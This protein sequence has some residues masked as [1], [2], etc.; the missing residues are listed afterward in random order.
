MKL[1]ILTPG[2]FRPTRFVPGIG[3]PNSF[4]CSERIEGSNVTIEDVLDSI[5]DQV[6]DHK[7]QGHPAGSEILTLQTGQFDLTLYFQ[8]RNL[9]AGSLWKDGEIKHYTPPSLLP[10]LQGLLRS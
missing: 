2:A 1:P 9:V 3:L 8:K 4:A 6:F 5:D 7:H 10:M